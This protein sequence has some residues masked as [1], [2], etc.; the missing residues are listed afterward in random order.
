M[1]PELGWTK[2]MI[3]EIKDCEF[4]NRFPII[5][6]VQNNNYEFKDKERDEENKFAA[7]LPI[8]Y[9][10]IFSSAHCL[11]EFCS[12]YDSE[13]YKLWGRV[14]IIIIYLSNFMIIT[15]VYLKN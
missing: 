7:N 5:I 2:E 8:S 4:N 6:K 15:L 10:G 14:D 12:G 1:T 9:K 11:Y 3:D 13:K